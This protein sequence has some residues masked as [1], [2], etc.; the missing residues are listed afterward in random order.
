MTLPPAIP[1]TPSCIAKGE[2]LLHQLQLY[3]M[4]RTC[5]S[6]SSEFINMRSVHFCCYHHHRYIVSFPI[7]LNPSPPNAPFPG[8]LKKSIGAAFLRLDA[9]PDINHMCGMQC[10]IVINKIF[11]PEINE[12]SCTNLC[13]E[14]QHKQQH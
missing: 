9:L 12:N 11:W 1:L 8:V 7:G 5:S 6:R 14:F 3:Q 10:Q 13:V 4:S 2:R